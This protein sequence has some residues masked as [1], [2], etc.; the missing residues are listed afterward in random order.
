M[1]RKNKISR[2]L[3]PAIAL[4]ILAPAGFAPAVLAQ[5]SA[6]SIEQVIVTGSRGKPRTVS[7]SPVPVDVFTADAIEASAQTD[8]NEIIKTLVPSFS[9]SRWNP[10][11]AQF[12]RPAELRGLPFDKTLVLVD[13]KRRHRGALVNWLTNGAQGPDMA[14]IPASAVKSIEVLR[15]GAAAQ[16][17]SDAIAGVINF[18]LKDNREGASLTVETAQ[19]DEGDGDQV[20]VQGNIGLPLGDN[21]FLSISGEFYEQDFTNRGGQYCRTAFSVDSTCDTWDTFIANGSPARVAYAQ[22]DIYQNAVASGSANHPNNLGGSEFA[23]QWGNPEME[24][25]RL[26][27]N[28][29]YDLSDS[30]ELY[31]FGNYSDQ[32]GNSGFFYRF[33]Y[34]G[35]VFNDIRLE[36]G[37]TYNALE[38]FPGGV[39]PRLFAEIEDVSLLAGWRGE[40]DN[41]LTYDFSV[42]HGENEVDYSVKNT[43]NPSMGPDSPVMFDLG[44]L[45]NTET[46]I[47]ADLTYELDNGTLLAFGA[48]W[49]D[50]EYD[51][52]AGVPDSYSVGP[53][54]AA[55][56]Y[57]F[58]SDCAASS[59]PVFETLGAGSNG[60]VG[61]SPQFSQKYTRDSM[62]LY[63]DASKD[64][65]DK[66][67]LQAA[68]RY[69]DYDDFSSE[70][71]W[72]LAG[73][74]DV[75]DN[76]GLRASI[77]TGFR[78]PTPGQQGSN[79]VTTRLPDGIPLTGGLFPAGGAVAAGVGASPLKPE[80]SEN[81]TLGFTTTLG[82]VDL[83][84]DYY[85]IDIEDFMYAA[86]ARP[87]SSDPTSGTAFDN[88]QALVASGVAIADSL[89]QVNFFTSAFDTKTEGLD[90][91]A[92]TP[93][94]W[95]DAGV[96][97]L[98]AAINYNK[99]EFDSPVSQVSEFLNAEDQ[100][101]FENINPNYRGIF[102]AQHE[103]DRFTLMARLSYFGRY[104]NSQRGTTFQEFDSIW[105]TDI[106]AAYRIN[107]NIRLS[108]G[109]RNIFNEYPD[110]DQI[111]DFI[112]G[113]F[114]GRINRID[115][116]GA[117]WYGRL[118][119][120]F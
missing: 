112:G 74:Y 12:M 13:S 15:D 38:V 72:K 89:Q 58:C 115:W 11:G 56:P 28:A 99:L 64:I 45:T 114:Y 18:L 63:V 16:Y 78:A 20:T 94:D 57:G 119:I 81:F 41:G 30:S 98:S 67:F 9:V 77:G 6:D 48:S 103:L 84:V 76:F 91:V 1:F 120:D 5:E 102:T 79:I 80:L 82:N 70:T 36:D 27:F 100:F 108:L 51:I 2:I 88:Y 23:M 106:E 17:G 21:G 85:R 25:N 53:H 55:D 43:V 104:D 33:P 65:T 71:V 92:T 47:Q 101:D 69:E 59:D 31:A 40:W 42:R 86:S 111:G 110:T 49:M 32:E 46:Q 10:D 93:I 109:G 117:L 37:S 8:M 90:I 62:A 96:T 75:T 34:N 113:D 3:T 60:F 35:S 29:G 39:T 54:A 107:D 105:F 118:N 26:F 4:A 66:L 24:A 50:E 73:Q 14:T 87:V 83:T 44:S 19:Y 52:G 95:G 22:S 68:L 61:Q 116:Q 7:D 97:T